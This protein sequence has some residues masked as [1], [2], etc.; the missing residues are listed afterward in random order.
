VTVVTVV[1]QSGTTSTS[2]TIT[3]FDAPPE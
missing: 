1:E 2:V 3:C